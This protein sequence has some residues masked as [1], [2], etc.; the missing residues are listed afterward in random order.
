[1]QCGGNK[2]IIKRY[3]ELKGKKFEFK[4]RKEEVR[5]VR[6]RSAKY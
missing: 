4:E 5:T 6:N 3:R 2:E 1:M